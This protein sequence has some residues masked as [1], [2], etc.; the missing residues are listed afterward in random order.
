MIHLISTCWWNAETNTEKVSIKKKKKS[1]GWAT[2]I[3]TN[4]NSSKRPNVKDIFEISNLKSQIYL[5]MMTMLHPKSLAVK[6]LPRARVKSFI[7][8]L[9]WRIIIFIQLKDHQLWASV[10]SRKVFKKSKK[11]KRRKIWIRKRRIC[12]TKRWVNWL[13]SL[14]VIKMNSRERISQYSRNL[15]CNKF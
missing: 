2:W 15:S 7:C 5:K 11:R 10:I 8:H 13:T 1:P 4:I 12:K 3:N 6:I 9:L 14:V